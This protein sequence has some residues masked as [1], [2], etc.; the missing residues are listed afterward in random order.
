MM[1]S[2]MG[3]PDHRDR[4]VDQLIDRVAIEPRFVGSHALLSRIRIPVQ[5]RLRKWLACP[6]R[7]V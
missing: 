7:R 3:L 4:P 5:I 6:R 1:P 2:L